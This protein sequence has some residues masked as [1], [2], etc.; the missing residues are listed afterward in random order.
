[1]GRPPKPWFWRARKVWC[2]ELKGE[3]VPLAEGKENKPAAM[4]AFYELMRSTGTPMKVPAAAS[5]IIEELFDLFLDMIAR[6]VADKAKED[7]TY[8]GYKRFL[9][10]A[11]RS[12]GKLRATGVKPFNVQTWVD[13]EHVHMKL[14]GGKKVKVIKRWGPT[15]RFNGITAVKRAFAW[16]KEMGYLETNPVRDMKKPTPHRRQDIPNP[17]DAA[18]LFAAATGPIGELLGAMKATGCR[19]KEVMTLT[20]DAIN[21]KQGTWTVRNKMRHKTGQTTRTVILTDKMIVVSKFLLGRRPEGLIFRNSRGNPW[22]RNAVGCAIGR[23]RARLDLGKGVV[24]Y[25]LRHLFGTDLRVAGVNDA[26]IAALMGH[27]STDMLERIYGRH[28]EERTDH[29]RDAVNKI[30]QDQP[31]PNE[32]AASESPPE[33]GPPASTT[34]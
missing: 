11:A 2:V 9:S 7:V 6:D 29:L 25:A 1:M 32:D 12:F 28:I 4:Q 5:I 22:T 19:P 31:T 33:E 15:T 17:E 16:G 24:A 14:K 3:R 23:L 34:P 10:S 8:D 21:I 26:T 27:S 30:D 18:K 20:A 13:G